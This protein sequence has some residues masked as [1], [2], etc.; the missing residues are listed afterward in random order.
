MRPAA[1]R[2]RWLVPSTMTW[3]GPEEW[4]G[5]RCTGDRPAAHPTGTALRSS[6]AKQVTRGTPGDESR[7]GVTGDTACP[8]SP[9]LFIP[10]SR[11][12]FRVNFK[13]ITTANDELTSKMERMRH[14]SSTAP[15][16]SWLFFLPLFPLSFRDTHNSDFPDTGISSSL[17]FRPFPY[18]DTEA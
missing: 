7:R 10:T 5:I 3:T 16:S 2:S 1:L 12:L 18:S 9:N 8:E 17:T 4:D 6:P 15:Y 14:P 13:Q 11:G